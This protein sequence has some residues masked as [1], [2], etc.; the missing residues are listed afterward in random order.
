MMSMP[1]PTDDTAHAN[2]RRLAALGLRVL[3]IKAGHKRPPMS[4]W[5]HAA[6]DDPDKI[7]NWYRGLYRDAGTGLA[8]GP[9]PC[10]RYLFALDIDTHDPAH[11]GW[12]ALADLEAVHGKLPDTWRSLTGAG[13]GHLIFAAPTGTTVR[14]QQASGNRIAAGIDVRGD[15]GQIVVAPTIHP[16]TGNAYAWE[17]GYAPWEHEIAEAPAWLLE[18]VAEHDQPAASTPTA[19]QSSNASAGGDDTLF[20]LHR[21]NWNWHS[22][23]LKRGWSPIPHQPPGDDTFWVRPGKDARAGHSAV[24]HG[25]D[26]PFVIFTTEIPSQWTA[27]GSLTR[28][29]SGWSFGAFGFYAATEHAGDRSVAYRELAD[30]YGTTVSLTDLIANDQP[31]GDTPDAS[32]D[33]WATR[34]LGHLARAI[35]SGEHQPEVPQHL[36]VEDGMPL[37][38]PGRLHSI[39]GPP[40][41]GKTWVA[42]CALVERVKA[43]EHVLMIDWE[44]AEQGTTQR[45]MQ[46]GC[47]PDELEVLFDYRNPS[48]SLLYGFQTLVECDTP[49]RLI[50]MDSAGEALAAQGVELNDDTGTAQWMQLAKK[51]ARRPDTPSVVMLDHVPKAGDEPAKYAIGSQRKLAAITGASYRCDTL[52]EP[53]KGKPGKLKLVVAKDRLGNRAKGTTACEVHIADVGELL[54]VRFAVSEAQA[55]H[56]RGEKFRPTVLMERVSKWL[57]FHPGA[58]KR[59]IH[60]D[61]NG[62]R[63]A[64]A[65]ALE[66][67]IDEGFVRVD[68]VGQSHE[69]TSVRP[70]FESSDPLSIPVDNLERGPAA[71]RGPTAALENGAAAETDRG[72]RGPVRHS[73]RDAGRGTGHENDQP[74]QPPRPAVD[75]SEE[76]GLF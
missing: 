53:A 67:L 29:G 17:H 38:Y 6:T 2:A 69:H 33:D 75:N 12:E 42:L 3:P 54:E 28:D 34:N 39:F 24:L 72:P 51:L 35:A 46:L 14:N 26:G 56:E 1:A 73:A 71:H 48:T 40:G 64:I 36:H 44:D 21:G 61:V 16:T 10:G 31:A 20:Q 50:V 49:W 25:T 47:T 5:Q 41:G 52:I 4:S 23:L 32:D 74:N 59:S 70:Y 45:L 9:Q 55:A 11:D 66:V 8:L 60:A 68:R 43:G 19:S 63:E 18:L 62:K 15:G 76:S 7:D 27:A 58:T 37:F 57:E 65:V 13:G 22:E 30:R